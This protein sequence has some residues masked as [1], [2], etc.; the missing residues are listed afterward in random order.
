MNGFFL[1]ISLALVDFFSRIP[2]ASKRVATPT[3]PELLLIYG[4]L[5]L[6]ANLGRWKR[7]LHG[8]LLLAGIYGGIQAQW[9]VSVQNSQEL[10]VTFLDVGQGD[11]AVLQLPRGKVMVI[12]GGGT[13]DGSF[14]PG[15]RIEDGGR[16]GKIALYI[17]WGEVAREIAFSPPL[18]LRLFEKWRAES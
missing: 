10:K 17:F 7:S 4:I 8:L 12:D 14:D 11:A 15:E 5:I 18:W 1:D 16:S 2:L 9:Y 3:I 6:A 13:P